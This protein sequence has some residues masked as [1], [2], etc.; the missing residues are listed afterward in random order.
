[1]LSDTWEYAAGACPIF[2]EFNWKDPL[3]YHRFV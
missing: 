3:L 2:I 1:M